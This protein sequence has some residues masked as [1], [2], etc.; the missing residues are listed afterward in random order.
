[1]DV[2]RGT[3]NLTQEQA[4]NFEE[5]KQVLSAIQNNTNRVPQINRPAEVPC[6]TRALG[7][8]RRSHFV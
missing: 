5:I 7:V 6:V 1:M 3:Q 4:R 2:I 8:V